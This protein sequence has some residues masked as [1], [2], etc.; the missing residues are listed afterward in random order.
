[1]P[2]AAAVVVSVAVRGSLWAGGSVREE[3]FRPQA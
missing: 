1:M 3:G 2:V